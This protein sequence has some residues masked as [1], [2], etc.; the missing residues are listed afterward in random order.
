MEPVGPPPKLNNF[1]PFYFKEKQKMRMEDIGIN[2]HF[3]KA[4]LLKIS[5]K[6]CPG[7]LIFS[8]RKNCPA[9]TLAVGRVRKVAAKLCEPSVNTVQ[10]QREHGVKP[11]QT[12]REHSA[13]PT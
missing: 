1:G 6:L 2:F 11:E 10:T 4:E 12:Q 9:Q 8:H 5:L 7:A 3:P 13:T